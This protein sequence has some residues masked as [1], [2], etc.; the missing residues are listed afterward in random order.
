MKELIDFLETLALS[1]TL[2][3]KKYKEAL[4][5]VIAKIQSGA[6]SANEL[7]KENGSKKRKAKKMKLGRNGL[8]PTEESFI[9]QWWENNDTNMD[10]VLPDETREDVHRKRLVHLRVRETQLQMMVILETL[11]LYPLCIQTEEDGCV[12][13]SSKVQDTTVTLATRKVKKSKH[14]G[15]LVDMH[16]DRLCIWQSVAEEES[17]TVTHFAR[18]LAPNTLT[19]HNNAADVLRDFCTEVIVP[20]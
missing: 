13:P 6:H 9:Q 14:M 3:D 19:G 7:G 15:S 16:V 10:L 11:A 18:E 4:P 2:I 8:Y 1:S 20:L 17:V 12:L 5:A